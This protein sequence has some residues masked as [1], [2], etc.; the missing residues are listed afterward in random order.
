MSLDVLAGPG[1]AAVKTGVIARLARGR[2]GFTVLDV[3]AMYR[4]MGGEAVSPSDDPE[5][6]RLASYLLAVAVRRAREQGVDGVV[7]TSNGSRSRIAELAE[8]AGGRVLITDPGRA[9]VCRRLRRVVPEAARREVCEQG[10][11]RW[12]GVYQPDPGD[13]QL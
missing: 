7:T 4:A 8:Q 6:F 11:D 10:L 12:Y 5:L 1:C 13:V 3:T 2:D 9:E